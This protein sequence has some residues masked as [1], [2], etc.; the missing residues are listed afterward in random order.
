MFL[1][2]HC[3]R[4]IFVALE[5]P[6]RHPTDDSIEHRGNEPPVDICGHAVRCLTWLKIAH[7]TAARSLRKPSETR[8]RVA[9]TVLTVPDPTSPWRRDMSNKPS[10]PP[11]PA[12]TQVGREQLA[13]VQRLGGLV[14]V[15]ALLRKLG[16]DPVQVFHRV[17]LR[18][19]DFESTEARI[20]YLAVGRLMGACAAATGKEH[21]GLLAGER[22]RLSHMGIVGQLMRYAP[23]VGEGLRT[24]IAHQWLN[25]GGGVPFLF[26]RNRVAELGYGIYL[27]GVPHADQFHDLALALLVQ[28]FREMYGAAWNPS[29]VLLP[30][31]E[32][33]DVKPYAR[34]FRARV[35]FNADR[36]ACRFPATELT[37]PSAEADQAQLREHERHV[38]AYGPEEL[39]PRLRRALRVMLAFGDTSAEGLAE[40]LAMHPRT[41]HRRLAEG[42]TSFKAAL[43][44][45]RFAVARQML[46][47]TAMPLGEIAAA[48]GYAESSPF[49]RAFRRWSGT[50]PTNWRRSR[51][52]RQARRA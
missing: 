4:R 52:T 20:P 51:P 46:E 30:R 41:L 14:E 21:F 10:S 2:V 11:I 16:G 32:P 27:S 37:R 33:A 40:R 34:F 42:G 24:G 6:N 49:V 1:Y 12:F 44:D 13:G 19:S 50:T 36:A 26:E 29:V 8:S 5:P 45:V 28:L 9:R 31:S 3:E 17:D 18:L 23:T 7:G 25:A 39:G 35:E 48:L 38:A 15:P 22:W 43:E 47:T